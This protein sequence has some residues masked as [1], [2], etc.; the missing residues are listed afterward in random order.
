MR[1]AGFC[2]KRALAACRHAA[3]AAI[4]AVVFSLLLCAAE[5]QETPRRKARTPVVQDY[6][7]PHFL[8]HTDLPAKDA[9]TLL[10]DLE[11]MLKLVST[12][13]ARPPSGIIECYVA[14]DIETWPEEVLSV[15]APKG[16]AKI[17][18][19]AGVCI[20]QQMSLGNR[21]VA[22]SIVYAVADDGVPQHEAVHGYC[23][24]T[25]GRTG[26]LWYAEGMAEVGRC[27]IDGAKG[28]NN[29]PVVIEY[30]QKSPPATVGELIINDETTGGTW[31][32]YAKW[33]SLCHFLE[34]NP[35]YNADFR[36]L[37]AALL[38]G[39]PNQGFELTFGSRAKELSFEYMLFLDQLEAGYRVELTAW[40]WKRKF[41]PLLARTTV[42]TPVLAARGWQ[43]T[44]ISIVAGVGHEYAASGTWQT[45]K[46]NKPVDANGGD[47]GAGRLVAVLMSDYKLCDEFELG[48]EGVLRREDSGD[49][50]VRCRDG[51]A[52][53]ADNTGRIT[54]RVKIEP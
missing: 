50:Y 51:W 28:V 44:G 23:Q 39:A 5:A 31:Q 33:W 24:Q 20:S 40:D 17:R 29:D 14:K 8:V 11:T 21:F 18:E 13:W 26:P 22:K 32:D 45:A 46:E 49:L 41:K 48:A 27:W 47:D 7:S 34:N 6:S 35:N 19:G 38:L 3:S 52:Q 10:K 36:K 12:Y 4:G 43:P 30:L 53:L 25:F 2:S 15:M 16:V 37:G 1:P 42:T 54:L 9:Q